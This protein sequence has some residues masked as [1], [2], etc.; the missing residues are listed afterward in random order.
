VDHTTGETLVWNDWR[1]LPHAGC[2]PNRAGWASGPWQ[3]GSPEGEAFVEFDGVN[4]INR[5]RASIEISG[6]Y[7]DPI[8]EVALAQIVNITAYLADQGRVTWSQYPMLRP[9]VRYP[10]N[11]HDFQNHKPCA[12]AVLIGM[13]DTIAKRVRERLK[14]YQGGT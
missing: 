11:H 14:Q 8:S 13:M 9:G 5:D 2:S 3:H 4:G 10:L 6:N 1:G 12:G 7:N